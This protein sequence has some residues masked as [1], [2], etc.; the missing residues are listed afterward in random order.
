MNILMFVYST[1]GGKTGASW[2]TPGFFVRTR[3]RG[4]C[5]RGARKCQQQRLRFG[6]HDDDD[7]YHHQ[8]GG[9]LCGR[10]RVLGWA[11][12]GTYPSDFEVVVRNSV[13]SVLSLSS[14]CASC[15][16]SFNH[17][18]SLFAFH[19]SLLCI[20]FDCLWLDFDPLLLLAENLIL[21]HDSPLNLPY[22]PPLRTLQYSFNR[23]PKALRHCAA[24]C[25]LCN[26]MV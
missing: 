23:S 12:S 10:A 14:P 20:C 17:L 13:S 16:F 18:C 26:S 24:A 4:F 2:E 21:L 22:K 8:V 19:L 6:N 1:L 15:I 5:W 11:A 3:Q 25:V 9:D 7:V